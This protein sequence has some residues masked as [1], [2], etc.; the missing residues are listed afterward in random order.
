[1]CARAFAADSEKRRREEGRKEGRKG[2]S[3]ELER[4]HDDDLPL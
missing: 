4:H 2:E 1:V 3:R